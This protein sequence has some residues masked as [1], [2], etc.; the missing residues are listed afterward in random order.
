MG[1]ELHR[2]Y[3]CR[4]EDIQA[5]V[6]SKNLDLSNFD[7]NDLYEGYTVRVWFDWDFPY[8]MYKNGRWEKTKTCNYKWVMVRWYHPLRPTETNCRTHI[9]QQQTTVTNY[10]EPLF[11][12]DGDIVEECY[13]YHDSGGIIRDKYASCR[14]YMP[15]PMSFERRGLPDDVSAEVKQF[16]EA[17]NDHGFFGVTYTTCDHLDDII[18]F[19][20]EQLFSK[21]KEQQYHG[22]LNLINKKLDII[23]K[24]TKDQYNDYEWPPKVDD[25]SDEDTDDE[26]TIDDLYWEIRSLQREKTR[27]MSFADY[28]C[29]IEESTRIIYFMTN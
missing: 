22:E 16:F 23:F 8:R 12:H 26:E 21:L 6:D 29:P 1:V 4:V 3:E 24:R 27:A 25:D 7:E 19:V 18:D 13:V 5:A 28:F 15:S 14:G 10:D 2:I 17:M 11:G 9:I 20:K